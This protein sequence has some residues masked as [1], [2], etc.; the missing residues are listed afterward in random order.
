MVSVTFD[1]FATKKTKE[2]NVDPQTPVFYRHFPFVML[3]NRSMDNR[4][5]EQFVGEN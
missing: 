3:Y 1:H 5:C 2:F 4:S